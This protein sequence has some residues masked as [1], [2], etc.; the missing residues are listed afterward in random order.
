VYSQRRVLF[1]LTQCRKFVCIMQ[2][3]LPVYYM[4]DYIIVELTSTCAISVFQ[5]YCFYLSIFYYLFYFI[6][7]YQY[8]FIYFYLFINIYL[9][10]FTY[11]LFFYFIYL[12]WGPSCSY[13][14]LICYYLCN[15]YLSPLK[16]WVRTPF[17]ARC[18]QKYNIMW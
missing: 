12:F 9:F 5:H 7:I 13:G 11:F 3:L 1:C 8:L 2:I 6:F 15:Q 18:T 4:R 17:M 16:L 10:I 14:S